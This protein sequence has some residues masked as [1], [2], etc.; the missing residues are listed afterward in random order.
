MI[1][2][3]KN[4]CKSCRYFQRYVKDPKGVLIIHKKCK[5]DLQIDIVDYYRETR[6]FEC[7]F[8]ES[9]DR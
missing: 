4:T 5:Y 1:S 3:L 8:Y 2:L 9:K 6:N 7:L